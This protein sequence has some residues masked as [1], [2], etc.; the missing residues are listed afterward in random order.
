MYAYIYTKSKCLSRSSFNSTKQAHYA[1][2]Y[3]DFSKLKTTKNFQNKKSPID[4][5]DGLFL[6]F[7]VLVENMIIGE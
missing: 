6:A 3:F 4:L 1:F 2:V 7:S 5:N